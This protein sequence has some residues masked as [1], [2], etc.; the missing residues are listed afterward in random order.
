M[1]YFVAE[2]WRT[3]VGISTVDPK[4]RPLDDFKCFYMLIFRFR[5]V[6]HERS[7]ARHFDNPEFFDKFQHALF[8]NGVF[9]EYQGTLFNEVKKAT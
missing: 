6:K 7:I 9:Q 4:P 5:N 2:H 3:F 8:E 1:G